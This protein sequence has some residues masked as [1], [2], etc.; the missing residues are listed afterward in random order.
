[1]KLDKDVEREVRA[2]LAKNGISVALDSDGR[3]LVHEYRMD[4]KA[5][6]GMLYL[7]PESQIPK[8]ELP[9]LIGEHRGVYGVFHV[10][11]EAVI[12][13]VSFMAMAAELQTDSRP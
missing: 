4:A 2:A 1:M 6:A 13:E 9:F 11:G 7:K 12:I 3:I 8:G 5:R 10:D